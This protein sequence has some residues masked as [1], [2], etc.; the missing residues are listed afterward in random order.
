M[1]EDQLRWWQACLHPCSGAKYGRTVHLILKDN[2]RLFNAPPRNN[3]EWDLKYNARTSSERCNKREKIDYKLEDGRHH[4]SK[5]WYLP[6]LC[7][8]NVPTS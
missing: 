1:P 5:M 3:K 7:H 2:P 4:S 8:H 6:P